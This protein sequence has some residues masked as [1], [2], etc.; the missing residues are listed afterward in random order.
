MSLPSHPSDPQLSDN[1][2]GQPPKRTSASS[3]QQPQRRGS[4]SPRL[5]GAGGRYQMKPSGSTTPRMG[6]GAGRSLGYTSKSP[7]SASRLQQQGQTMT[8]TVSPK[9]AINVPDTSYT[10]S[11][12]S[13]ANSNI[14]QSPERSYSPQRTLSPQR[15][16]PATSTNRNASPL[17]SS[18]PTPTRSSMSGIPRPGSASKLP[19]PKK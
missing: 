5:S 18:L 8:R 12:P 9:R 19:G 16:L 10:T 11:R 14:L 15:G 13:T 4:P 3:V 17:R 6:G 2:S 1:T 7:A